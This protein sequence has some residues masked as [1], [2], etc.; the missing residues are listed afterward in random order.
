MVLFDETIVNIMSNFIPN[1][2]MTFDDR[3]PP[4]LNKNNDN[5]LLSPNQSGFRTGDWYINQLLSIT[6]DIFHC[7]NEGMETRAI[8][9]DVS[10]AFDK[11]WHK[12]II[13]K[14]RQYVF[15]GNLF[16]LLTDFLSN[17]KQR[18]VLNGQHSSWAD[19]KAGVPLGSILGPLLF[20][21][22]INDLT[23]NLHSHPKLFADDTS[24]F[25]TA[26]DEAFSNSY[27]NDDLKNMNEWSYKWKMSFNPDSTKPAHEFAF[28]RKKKYLLPSDFI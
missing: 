11:V 17:R 18:V 6:Y 7:F 15:T 19:I 13:Y 24:L 21:V 4:W 1:E 26:T 10:K 5:N 14:L 23:E 20:L 12:G 9:L 28:S 22:Y 2:T 25:S 27:L 16:A 3:D 8:F